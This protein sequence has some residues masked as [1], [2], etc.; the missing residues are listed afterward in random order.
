MHFV[1]PNMM[2][3]RRFL[4]L[5]EHVNLY[6]STRGSDLFLAPDSRADE[7]RAASYRLV[8]ELICHARRSRNTGLPTDLIDLLE[9]SHPP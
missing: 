9:A 2:K 3:K 6:E 8:N 5:P 4:W 7:V 1:P